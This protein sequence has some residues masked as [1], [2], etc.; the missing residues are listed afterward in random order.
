MYGV[1]RGLFFNCWKEA[2]GVMR[3]FSCEDDCWRGCDGQTCRSVKF[4]KGFSFPWLECSKLVAL[5]GSETFSGGE[6]AP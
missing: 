5:Q 3:R 2:R 4:M 6:D 1:L